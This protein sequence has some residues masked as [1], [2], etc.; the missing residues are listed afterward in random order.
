MFRHNY[1]VLTLG[2]RSP[3]SPFIPRVGKSKNEK[4]N[5]V[6]KKNFENFKQLLSAIFHLTAPNHHDT[7]HGV[8]D[9]SRSSSR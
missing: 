2:P 9:P 4:E 3:L 1:V 7:R 5:E 8:K 6:H